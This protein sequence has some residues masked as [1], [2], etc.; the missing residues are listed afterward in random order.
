MNKDYYEI[1]GLNKYATNDEIKKSY[2]KLALKHHPD[3]NQ[4]SEE[5]KKMFQNITEAYSV[6]G[7]EEK[8][9]KYDM[10]GIEDNEFEFDEDPFKMF[11]SIF[12]EHLHQFQN[13]DMNMHYEKSF[14][15]NDIIQEM[16][17][18]N[19][20][21]LFNIPKVHVQVHSLNGGSGS[22]IGSSNIG[23]IL[24][25]FSEMYND[26]SKNN[27]NINKNEKKNQENKVEEIIEDIN[28][29]VDI[30]MKDI[31][32]KNK[33]EIKYQKDRYKNKK[34][35]KKNV[36]FNI[37]IYDKEI[38]LIG[39]GNETKNAKGNVNIYIHNDSTDFVRI[40][41]Y[42]VYYNKSISLKD[43]YIIKN[44]NN[45]FSVQLPNEE[46]VYL[47]NVEGNKIIK[48]ENKG[49]P[50]KKDNKDD[51]YDYG[52]LFCCFSI[53]MPNEIDELYD[54]TNELIEDFVDVDV[55]VDADVDSEINETKYSYVLMN[56]ILMDS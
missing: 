26:L 36:K 34:I 8:R 51:L 50:Y 20:G 52:D 13:M 39:N 9:K 15:V 44:K 49:I 28:I 19:L 12:K 56:E 40:N 3:K 16:S 32:N 5:S 37:D 7:D 17:G 46:V 53:I 54:I 31:Y 22:R 41:D 18:F 2:K 24:N 42:D 30:T 4:D 43:Y 33:K 10:F 25:G 23:N 55:D 14:D 38:I 48:I 1:L 21:N 27:V 29:H 6:L 11:N 45:I 35:V 47:K